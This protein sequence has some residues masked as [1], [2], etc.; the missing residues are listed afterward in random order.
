MGE[1]ADLALEQGLD[2]WLNPRD[3]YDEDEPSGIYRAFRD[4]SGSKTRQR[5][6]AR[7]KALLPELGARLAIDA[8]GWLTLP[9]HLRPGVI[10]GTLIRITEKAILINRP[11][12]GKLVAGYEENMW[13]PLAWIQVIKKK[14]GSL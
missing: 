14:E 9:K 2:E 11:S 4:H 1:M 3:E 13:F 7:N 12:V 8:P 10:C 5:I 6:L